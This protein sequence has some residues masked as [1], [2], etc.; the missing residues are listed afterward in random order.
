MTA[1]PQQQY[2]IGREQTKP[3]DIMIKLNAGGVIGTV[4]SKLTNNSAYVHGGLAV[5]GCRLIEVNGGLDKDKFR[6]SRTMANI[7]VTN[8]KTDGLDT[9]YDVWRCENQELAQEVAIQAYPFAAQGMD[10]SWGYNLKA[11]V[12]SAGLFQW[13]GKKEA[14][15]AD[16]VALLQEN[17]SVLSVAN[18]EKRQFF[19]TQF[20]AWIYYQVAMLKGFDP[21][22]QFIPIASKDASP[23]ALVAALEKSAWFRYA[24]TIRG[25]DKRFANNINPAPVAV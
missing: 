6:K 5:G 12:Q 3:G 18:A 1:I 4:I 23:A 2:G 13:L 25:V 24:G 22:D 7:Y 17:E 14:G 8:L 16:G 10:K 9:S 15:D 21:P 19:C 11:A 20:V